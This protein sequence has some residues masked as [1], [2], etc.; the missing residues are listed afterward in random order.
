MLLQRPAW[1][2][3]R[4]EEGQRVVHFPCF[5]RLS[6]LFV[7]LMAL[8]IDLTRARPVNSS[9][10]LLH[11]IEINI[12]TNCFLLASSPS[13]APSSRLLLCGP[14]ARKMRRASLMRRMRA[15]VH[16]WMPPRSPF[17]L[18]PF[19]DQHCTTLGLNKMLD[20]R[21]LSRGHR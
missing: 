5:V 16:P 17:Q 2:N 21:L 3:L 7:A 1:C 11:F 19:R 10:R 8:I 4:Q 9:E 15:L 13:L 18:L 20:L 12:W 6:D 14:I